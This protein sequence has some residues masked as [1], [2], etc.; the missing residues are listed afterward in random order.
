MKDPA[1]RRDAIKELVKQL[2][3]QGPQ[4][5]DQYNRQLKDLAY[6]QDTGCGV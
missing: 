5:W 6:W 4:L 3:N 2:K 1:K